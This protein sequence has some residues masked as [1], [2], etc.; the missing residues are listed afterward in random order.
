M[1]AKKYTQYIKV[2]DTISFRRSASDRI[3]LTP[4][5]KTEWVT[6]TVRSTWE[7]HHT[8][9][10]GDPANNSCKTNGAS[11]IFY[12]DPRASADAILHTHT[13]AKL[14]DLVAEINAEVCELNDIKSI[15]L[16]LRSEIIT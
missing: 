12:L 2:G 3:V 14:P 6:G 15:I 4:H 9:D 8:V 5:E 7:G 11:A 10:D 13:S 16:K 1:R